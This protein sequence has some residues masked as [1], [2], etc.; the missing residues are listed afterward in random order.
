MSD[1]EEENDNN[2]MLFSF[3]QFNS[4]FLSLV[5]YIILYLEILC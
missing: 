3:V 2:G 4:A 1:D 5:V